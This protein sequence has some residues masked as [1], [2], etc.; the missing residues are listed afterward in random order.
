MARDPSPPVLVG[1]VINRFEI[2]LH[3][4]CSPSRTSR[5]SSRSVQKTTLAEVE[6]WVTGQLLSMSRTG[7]LGMKETSIRPTRKEWILNLSVYEE[8]GLSVQEVTGISLTRRK[9][10]ILEVVH[11]VERVSSQRSRHF[12]TSIMIGVNLSKYYYCTLFV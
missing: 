1:T 10:D 4:D 12:D 8:K 3:S 7:I 9:V 11:W 6:S 2:S 5:I